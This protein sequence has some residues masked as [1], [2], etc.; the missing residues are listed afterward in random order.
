MSTA[1][2]WSGA[3]PASKSPRPSRTWSLMDWPRRASALPSSGSASPYTSSSKGCNTPCNSS[4]SNIADASAPIRPVMAFAS[5]LDTRP[6]R[7]TYAN[8]RAS[9]SFKRRPKR[10]CTRRCSSL[11]K[12]SRA[13]RTS[14]VL[15]ALSLSITGGTWPNA[16]QLRKIARMPVPA[17]SLK[18]NLR[19]AA[20]MSG[21]RTSLAPGSRSAS[22]VAKA[23]PGFRNSIRS[24][25]RRMQGWRC[26]SP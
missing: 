3:E 18:P 25:N 9:A 2:R 19:N 1:P 20:T 10:D 13:R 11:S 22:V 15:L 7:Q 23:S 17:C 5:T 26:W 8:T 12:T 14:N 21:L 16:C 24:R 4:A 6:S